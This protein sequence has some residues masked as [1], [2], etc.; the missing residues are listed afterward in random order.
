MRTKACFGLLLCPLYTQQRSLTQETPAREMSVHH[1]VSGR[2]P[3]STEQTS[4]HSAEPAANGRGSG[5]GSIE[6]PPSR[7]RQA[8]A[9][10]F[11]RCLAPG[12]AEPEG[13]GRARA[14]C[15]GNVTALPSQKVSFRA[16]ISIKSCRYGIV[17]VFEI[18]AKRYPM[19]K[20]SLATENTEKHAP[21]WVSPLV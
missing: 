14:R 21:R 8:S 20:M 13:V 10:G 18:S 3:E 17:T 19:R 6:A 15:S 5:C 12:G 2:Q 1:Q 4:L 11:P 16:L 7:P 9:Q